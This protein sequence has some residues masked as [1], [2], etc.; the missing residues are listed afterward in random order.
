MASA[1]HVRSISLPSRPHQSTLYFDIQL[2][3][4]RSLQSTS[5]SFSLSGY[6]DLK[7]GSE[8][9]EAYI[10]VKKQ[11]S[12]EVCKCL[13]NLKSSQK[14]TCSNSQDKDSIMINA[15]RQ[16]E[17]ACLDTFE[18]FLAT[19][20]CSKPK[21]QRWSL[22]SKLVRSKRVSCKEGINRING[23]E[24]MEGEIMGSRSNKDITGGQ[25][26]NLLKVKTRVS[27][28]NILSH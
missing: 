21:T 28:L 2:E 13:R 22:V 26:K 18:S 19:I 12:K 3:R 24:R 9:V 27:I 4:L 23:I 14:K 17:E 11:L 5:S 1:C 6:K 16:P 20:A 15:L 25:L 8:L 10:A 7:R